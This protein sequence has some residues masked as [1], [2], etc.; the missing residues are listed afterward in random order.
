MGGPRRLV[1]PEVEAEIRRLVTRFAIERVAAG[2]SV[3]DLAQESGVHRA[4]INRFETGET[5]PTLTTLVGLSRIL[6]LRLD[7]VPKHLQPL[8]ALDEF[9][10]RALIAFAMAA[11]G[12][13]EWDNAFTPQQ[14]DAMLS[15]LRKLTAEHEATWG[16][17]P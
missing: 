1:T 5:V 16:V 3:W 7:V 8:L 10:V 12:N 15:A 2:W 9:E 4:N 14:R 17:L 13:A 6:G 11:A